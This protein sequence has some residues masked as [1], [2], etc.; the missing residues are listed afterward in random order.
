MTRAPWCV[1][2]EAV[3]SAAD[4]GRADHVAVVHAEG[5]EAQV[6]D[7]WGAHSLAHPGDTLPQALLHSAPEAVGAIITVRDDL[8]HTAVRATGAEDAADARP[9]SGEE[10]LLALAGISLPE[11]WTATARWA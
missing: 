4:A 3:R 2:T 6:A 11:G 7:W 8:I 10:R 9:E 1:R 5:A